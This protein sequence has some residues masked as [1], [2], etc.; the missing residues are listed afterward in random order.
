MASSYGFQGVELRGI[1]STLDIRQ[2]PEFSGERIA[3]TRQSFENAGI[4]IVSVDSSASLSWRENDKITQH[5]EEAK[6]Y[7]T[8]AGKLG[9][10]LVRVFGG[11]IPS[12]VT[13]ANAVNYLA[14]NLSQLGDFAQ[15]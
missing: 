10:P 5:R 8:L 3:R 13:P 4:D 6:D 9:A 12:G 14:D 11:F 2:T 1:N 7:I 15:S